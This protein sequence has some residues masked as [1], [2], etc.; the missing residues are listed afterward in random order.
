MYVFMTEGETHRQREEQAPHREPNV[1]FDP[2]TPGSS[3]E[4]KSGPLPLSHPDVSVGH[5]I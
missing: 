2:G 4:L 1:G 3:H 5:S